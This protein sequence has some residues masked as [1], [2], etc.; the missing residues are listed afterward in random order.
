[1]A[2]AKSNASPRTLVVRALIGASLAL[3]F[4]GAVT[5]LL[6]TE[7]FYFFSS[8]F[9]LASGLRRLAANQQLLLAA[10]IALFSLCVPVIKAIVIWLAASGHAS[11]RRLPALADRFGKWS[12]LEVFVAALLITALKLGPVVDAKLHYG[13]YLL[14]SSVLVSGLASQLLPHE[15]HAGPLFSSA[16]TLTVGAVGGAVAATLLI[17]LLNP[18]AL[19]LEALVGTP[20]SRCIE[21]VLRLDRL[22]AQ[23]SGAQAEYVGHLRS[24]Q[25]QACPKAFTDAF[26]AYVEAWTQLDALDANGDDKPSWLER[27]GTR[28]GVIATR[29]DRLEDIEEAWAEIERVA[30]ENGIAEPGDRNTVRGSKE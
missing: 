28:V 30:L 24:I 1:M 10:V 16:V 15:H 22:S 8:T 4:A 3:L 7:R 27:A 5:P 14:A 12:M 26:E 17:G 6:T 20:E 25:A 21:R 2:N 18:G 9:S 23:T 11:S 19:N 13:A 29:D